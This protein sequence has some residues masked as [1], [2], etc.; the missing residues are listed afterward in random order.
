M[1]RVTVSAL[2]LGF[3][4]LLE[5]LALLTVLISTVYLIGLAT[6][7]FAKP[8]RARRFL[9]SFAS[10]ASIHF[11]ELIIRIIVGTAFILYA[12]Q[13]KF[14]GVFTVFG[15][16]LI[17]TT[18]VLFFVP[19]KLHRRF[20]EWAVPLATKRMMLLGFGSYIAGLFILFS[21]FLGP[22]AP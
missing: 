13:M 17:V 22:D 10:T 3:M 16:V 21:F 8:E 5:L 7:A 6:A 4:K 15:W 12:P 9:H 2:G 19:W 1:E 11:I 20:A 18:V 14:S